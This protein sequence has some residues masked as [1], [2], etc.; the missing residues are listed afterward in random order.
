VRTCLRVR[1]VFADVH[2]AAIFLLQPDTCLDELRALHRMAPRAAIEVIELEEVDSL[3]RFGVSGMPCWT[4]IA[5]TWRPRLHRLAQG[6]ASSR[7][8]RQARNRG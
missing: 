8:A 6:A 4:R 1:C 5:W 2:G 7:A 3:D